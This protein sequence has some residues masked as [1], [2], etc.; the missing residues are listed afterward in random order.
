MTSRFILDVLNLNLSS[1]RLFV[2]GLFFVI[3]IISGTVDS[4]MII[5]EPVVANSGRAREWKGMTVSWRGISYVLE[6]S[7][8]FSHSGRCGREVG[9]RRQVGLL[10]IEHGHLDIDRKGVFCVQKKITMVK[11]DTGD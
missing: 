2:L 7:L 3:V 9:C 10:D 8:A 1:P 6:S 5:D 11:G 4:I